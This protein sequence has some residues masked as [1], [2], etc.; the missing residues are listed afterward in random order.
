MSDQKP[1]T[2]NNNLSHISIQNFKAFGKMVDVPI[3]PI[4]LIFGENSSG[5]S[6]ILHSLLFL[7]Q[8]Q[9]QPQDKLA[10]ITYTKVG[11]NSVDL[12]GVPQLKY[13]HSNENELVFVIEKS[14]QD[15]PKNL[16]QILNSDPS[17]IRTYVFS[18]K[19]NFSNSNQLSKIVYNFNNI[20]FVSLHKYTQETENTPSIIELDIQLDNFIECIQHPIFKNNLEYN[21]QNKEFS[22][23]NSRQKQEVSKTG[24]SYSTFIDNQV[25]YL[26]AFKNQNTIIRIT[27]L[28][29]SNNANIFDTINLNR[30]RIRDLNCRIHSSDNFDFA[31]I[32]LDHKDKYNNSTDDLFSALWNSFCIRFREL[33][34]TFNHISYL[35]PIRT[36]PTRNFDTLDSIARDPSTGSTSWEKIASDTKI[37]DDVNTWLFKFGTNKQLTTEQLMDTAQLRR[38]LSEYSERTQFE[39]AINK[40]TTRNMLRFY[41][42]QKEIYLSHRDFGVGISQVLPVI[43]NCV[44]NNNTTVLIEQPELHLHPRLQGDLA[45]LFIKTAITGSQ[46]NTYLLE[47]HSEALILRLLRRVREGVIKHDD[48]AILYVSAS[49]DGS[50][51]THIRVDND[52]D[53]MDRWPN[54]FFEETYRD[55]MGF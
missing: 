44:A 7:N 3:R 29:Y 45:D 32:I 33:T 53:F 41:D 35:G 13:N 50:N 17:D 28:L 22:G 19:F 34:A 39:L 42:P 25:K 1:R 30:G 49:E 26:S 16:I 10:D 14:K 52:G 31:G 48:I 8:M 20:S 18:F 38:L 24:L 11:G 54:G 6:S 37:R 46:E 43:V 47:T 51:I 36:I 4:T 5:K 23:K 9:Y 40:L 21:L 27:I 55:R 2:N 12:G 15:P